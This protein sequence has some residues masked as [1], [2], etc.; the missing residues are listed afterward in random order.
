MKTLIIPIMNGASASFPK[1]W[2]RY[3]SDVVKS[4]SK[5]IMNPLIIKRANQWLSENGVT[6]ENIRIITKTVRGGAI[7]SK[8]R[9]IRRFIRQNQGKDKYLLACGKSYGAVN[10]SRILRKWKGKLDYEKTHLFLVD[11]CWVTKFLM[12]KA[13]LKVPWVDRVINIFQQGKGMSGAIVDFY[14]RKN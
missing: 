5:E 12:P 9:A 2:R 6:T 10:I 4:C 14:G 3:F 7:F 13:K 1:H 11:P 8:K